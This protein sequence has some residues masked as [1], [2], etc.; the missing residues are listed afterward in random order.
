MMI[1]NLTYR[2]SRREMETGGIAEFELH[3]PLHLTGK[4]PLWALAQCRRSC[5][6]I[7]TPRRG[8]EMPVAPCL[9]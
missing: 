2:G 9:G 8:V 1:S 5:G 3:W 4:Y 6:A 7:L